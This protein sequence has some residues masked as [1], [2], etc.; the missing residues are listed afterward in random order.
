MQMV[1]AGLLGSLNAMIET[2][3][4]FDPAT[5]HVGVFESIS[6]QGPQAVLADLTVPDGTAFPRLP[7]TAWS[8]PYRLTDGSSVVDGPVMQ[9]SP[10]DDTTPTVLQGWYI[11]TALT[12][13]AILA[14]GFFPSPIAVPDENA[15]AT[16]VLRLVTNATAGWSA[17]V[18]W[19]G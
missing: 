7:V 16:L 8:T 10:P 9:F 18:S 4:V 6:V 17:E 19:N 3:N 11:A 15:A 2:G 1:Y 13:G 14:Y 12:A 5:V